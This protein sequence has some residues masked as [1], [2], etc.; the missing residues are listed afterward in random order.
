MKYYTELSNLES[1]LIRLETIASLVSVI[2]AGFDEVNAKD[3]Q[4]SLFHLEDALKGVNDNLRVEFDVLWDAVRTD[5]HDL[6]ETVDFD[7]EDDIGDF[8]GEESPK[9]YDFSGVEKAVKTWIEP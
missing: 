2:T 3:I 6:D 8:D 7:D 5:T 4:N 9:E 1:E